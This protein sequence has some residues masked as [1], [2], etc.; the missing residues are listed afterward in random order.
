MMEWFNILRTRLRA[1]FRRESVLQDIEEELRIHV[2]M[3]TERNIE[4]GMPPDEAQAAARK[5]FGQL[6]RNTELSY[7]IRG[8]GWLETFW[9]DLRYGARMLR[10]QPGF[11]LIAVLTL[12]LGIGANTAIFSVVNAV[13]VKPLLYPHSDLVVQIWQTNPRANRWGEWISYPAFVDYRRQNRVFEDIGAYRTWL[14][15]I[16]G[17]DHPEVLR[18]ARVT[19]NLFSVLSVQPI[20]GR[21]F[22]PEEEQPGRNQVVILSYGFWQRRFGSD[23]ALVGKTVTIDGLNHTVVGVMPPGFDL[24]YNVSSAVFASDAWIPPG[25]DPELE[26]RGSPNYRVLARL[27]PGITIQQAQANIEA[28]ALGLAE[29]YPENR[30][31]SATVVGLQQNLVKEARPTLLL[32]LGA[33]GF[34]LLIACA[35]VA[36][37]QLTRTT[38]RQ[39]EAAIRLAFGASRLQLIRQ[40]LTESMLLALLGGAAGLLLAVWGV[41]FLVRLGPDIPRLQ[42]TS[43]DPRVISFTLV[44]S[45]ATGVIFGMAPAFQGSRIDLNETLKESGIRAPAGSGR[46]RTRS[47]LV[48]AEM[49]LALMLLISAGLFIQSFMRLQKVDPGFNP[50]GVLTAY[51]MLPSSKYTE[52][53]RQAAFFKEV[54][55]R[56]EAL[57]GVEAV[58]G[59]SSMPLTGTNDAGYFRIEGIPERR[60]GDPLIEAEQPKITPGYIRAME[61]PVLMGRSFNWADN[62]NSPQVAVVSEALVQL[63][64]PNEDPIGKRLSINNDSDGKPVW[65]QIVGVVKD[66]KHDGLAKQPRPVI[67]SPLLQYPVPYTILAIRT[68]TDPSSLSPAIRRAVTAVDSEQP[69]FR[70]NTMERFIS[71]SVSDSRFQ[72]QLLTVFAAVALALAAVGIYGVVGYSVNQRTHEI[73]IRLALGARQRDVLKM[74]VKQGMEL[75]TTGVVIG[76]AGAFAL[77]RLMKDFLFGVNASDPLTFGVI[78]LILTLIALL[79]CYF[80]AR[81]ATKVD[82][83]VALRYE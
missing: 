16:T 48:I 71:D 49:A 70:I 9:Q 67:F 74:V 78:A 7:D 12:A 36:N 76:L 15:N 38:A 24:P 40:L 14:W 30:E 81:R 54:I 29:Q 83:L 61:I 68:H 34:V 3:E 8:G 50:H 19:S 64:W 5:S 13:L 42:D 6:S 66:V 28:I 23:P 31:M 44:L 47:L 37:L 46:G 63:Y 51:I 32:L 21:S 62:E 4:R 79:A 69:I 60:A 53:R 56:I 52:P 18:G 59:A 75:A 11:S 20:I 41:E 57:P 55:N 39:K 80:P 27:K 65:R 58:G 25:D 73:G 17:G 22:L 26:D 1:L 10:K 43:I 33:V 72:T 45:L 82:P 77:T 2:E 35:N